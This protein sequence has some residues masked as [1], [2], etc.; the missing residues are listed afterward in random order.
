MDSEQLRILQQINESLKTMNTNLQSQIGLIQGM[1]QNLGQT[2]TNLAGVSTQAAQTQTT[3]GTT[4]AAANQA[5]GDVTSSNAQ[6]KASTTSTYEAMLAAGKQGLGDMKDSTVSLT[7]NTAAALQASYD[8]IG[9][10]GSRRYDELIEL[11]R[12][13]GASAR[14]G[15]DKNLK[16][17][18]GALT[19]GNRISGLLLESRKNFYSQQKRMGGLMVAQM[20]ASEGD[21]AK[22]Q[23]DI[24]SA[25]IT[26]R[27]L[28][29]DMTNE[30]V[31]SATLLGKGMGYSAE[32]TREMLDQTRQRF[33]TS[34]TKMLEQIAVLAAD[35]EKKTGQSSKKIARGIFEMSQDFYSFGRVAPEALTK[36]V[37][38][39]RELGISTSDV[40]NIMGGFS[41]FDQ[42][43]EKVGNL[44]QLLG[45]N[46]DATEMMRLSATDPAAALNMLRDSFMATGKSITEL[47]PFTLREFAK[48]ANLTGSDGIQALTD[49][50][51]GT[52]SAEEALDAAGKT[53]SKGVAEQATAGAAFKALAGDI[54]IVSIKGQDLI[55]MTKDRLSG[56][57]TVD[58]VEGAA[59]AQTAMDKLGTAMPIKAAGA[60]KDGASA[61]A[62]VA[63][64]D[65]KQ[66]EA[67][68]DA[69]GPAIGKFEGEISK[70]DSST[71]TKATG[72]LKA[73]GSSFGDGIV[74]S[75][76]PVLDKFDGFITSM[77]T[78]WS[79][80]GA[81]GESPSEW[82]DQLTDG[83]MGPQVQSNIL[84]GMDTLVTG[85][86]GQGS[87]A[88]KAVSKTAS[89]V[90]TSTGII[91]S[92][93]LEN[94][95]TD[96]AAVMDSVG[97]KMNSVEFPKWSEMSKTEQNLF[98]SEMD[99][100]VN[101]IKKSFDN[102]ENMT[103]VDIMK[104]MIGE[105]G[106]LSEGVATATTN[107][108][109][110]IQQSLNSAEKMK[111]VIAQPVAGPET[112]AGAI[113]VEA[114]SGLGDALNAMNEAASKLKEAQTVE[115]TGN[116]EHNIN[117]VWNDQVIGNMKAALIGHAGNIQFK[118]QEA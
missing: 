26:G 86:E 5:V 111:A 89:K 38:M 79:K 107:A 93:L 37:T 60:L 49:L 118:T 54:D 12:V 34:G 16:D 98:A 63:G 108:V 20:F 25:S 112:A 3:L 103:P 69:I 71:V 4:S 64:V 21:F 81:K 2:K 17:F 47:D 74:A 67:G 65:L 42:A 104:S 99:T 94:M 59:K 56:A 90:A 14:D 85:M 1:N 97:A 24:A 35:A 92:T 28:M 31:E 91:G 6:I 23:S 80:S 10:V 51:N 114:S 78:K 18:R 57:L 88:A 45:M 116:S 9:V 39:M 52:K 48:Q 62:D 73:M 50:M 106:E 58:M 87:K 8:L 110:S 46:L 117:I 75:F 76:Q 29:R 68:L 102:I 7:M 40:T 55:K 70:L 53:G 13:Y 84:N 33:G 61:L 43:A 95:Q 32:E 27:V 41:S 11:Q 30:Q 100:T 105:E 113:M 109:S 96:Q 101:D 66:L 72:N 15:Y 19:E 82:G 36:T 115:V 44:T 22:Y 83:L 77:N